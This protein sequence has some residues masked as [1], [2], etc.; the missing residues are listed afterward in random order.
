M[1][2]KI[3]TSNIE[4]SAKEQIDKIL[5]IESFKENKIRIMPDVHAGTGCVVGFTAKLQDKIIPNII[6][7]D[8]GC[9]M[10]LVELGDIDIDFQKLDKVI[11]D[12][13]PSGFN[14]HDRRICKFKDL[15]NLYCYRELKD[16]KRL[17][18]SL[19]TLGGGNHFIEVDKDD[20]N[21]KYLII[22]TGSRNLG[23]QVADYYQQL[24]IDLCK[25]K[26]E[27]FK[28]KNEIIKKYKEQNR[29]QD[30][31]NAI[32]NLYSE[33]KEK[34]LKIPKELCYLTDEY[35][36]Q[37]LHD[38][39]ICQ[40]FAELNRDLIAEIILD[41]MNWECISTFNTIH[42]YI[43]FD[44]GV[45]RKGAISAHKGEKLLIP[46]N[47]KDG[48]IIG[49]G[50]GNP[51]WNYSAPHGAGRAMSRKQAKET[52]SFQEFQN[53]MKDIYSTTVVLNTLDEAPMAYKSIDEIIDNIK[54]TVEI[55]KRIFPIYNFKAIE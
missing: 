11:Q 49:I 28:K 43:N 23:K 36:E 53:T 46:L 32:Q 24:A 51:D 25:G 21:N 34:E 7:V 41:K 40:E 2:L 50:K 26:D 17:H 42:N 8:I 33:F 27:L 37:Y 1:D 3:F 22:H 14:T 55:Q 10:K 5:S 47:M 38:M 9:G 20:E 44:D 16:A 19:G 29:K 15:E 6:G 48:C 18:R 54:D 13:I 4:E 39:K 35:V 52:L 30:I 45:M 31:Q 12:N